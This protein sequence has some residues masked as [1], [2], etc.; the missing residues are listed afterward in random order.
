MLFTVVAALVVVVDVVEF[1]FFYSNYYDYCHLKDN[2]NIIHYLGISKY[3]NYIK[4]SL[5]L[6]CGFIKCKTNLECL[7][8]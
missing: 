1:K 5:F 7:K 3:L 2:N 8:G 4:L 6:M